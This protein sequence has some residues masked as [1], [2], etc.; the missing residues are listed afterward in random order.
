[1]VSRGLPVGSVASSGLSY[2][3][4]YCA[5]GVAGGGLL[6]EKLREADAGLRVGLLVERG[7]VPLEHAQGDA[8]VRGHMCIVKLSPTK[9]AL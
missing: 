5:R 8:H 1:M 4:R 7:Q 6:P 3:V 9:S 2:G